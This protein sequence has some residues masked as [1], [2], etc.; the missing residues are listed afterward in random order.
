MLLSSFSKGE[1]RNELQSTAFQT[2]TTFS[3]SE[4]G[5][6]V[7]MSLYHLFLLTDNLCMMIVWQG[8]WG[9]RGWDKMSGSWGKR[10]PTPEDAELEDV[11]DGIEKR[12]EWGKFKGKTYSILGNPITFSIILNNSQQGQE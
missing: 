2:W 12:P 8:T 9:K 6:C 4:T 11:W 3:E 7:N 10:V 1:S 5:C